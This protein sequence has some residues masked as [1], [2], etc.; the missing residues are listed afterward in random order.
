[1]NY[2][3]IVYLSCLFS[4]VSVYIVQCSLCTV[5]SLEFMLWKIDYRDARSISQ[6]E[7]SRV[8]YQN[9]QTLSMSMY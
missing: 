5:R 2:L 6:L 8:E 7:C 3:I 9:S 4:L 1:M